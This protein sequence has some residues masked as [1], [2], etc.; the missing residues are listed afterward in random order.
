MDLQTNSK[1]YSYAD[2]VGFRAEDGDLY[3][4]IGRAHV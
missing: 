1:L 3:L 2:G 4:E